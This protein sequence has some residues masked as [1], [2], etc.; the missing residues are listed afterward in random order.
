M[1]TS[2]STDTVRQINAD[3]I[4]GVLRG[5]APLTKAEISQQSGLSYPTCNTIVN[6]L[7]AEGELLE[8]TIPAAGSGRPASRYHYNPDWGQLLC[9]L[10]TYEGRVPRVL[11]AAHDPLGNLLWSDEQTFDDENI[12]TLLSLLQ[13]FA[14][15][16]PAPKAAAVAVPGPTPDGR[17]L[18]FCDIPALR[19]CPL[20]DMLQEKLSVPVAIENDTNLAALGLAHSGRLPQNTTAAA[21]YFSK[22]S[23]PGAGLLAEGRILRGAAGFAGEVGWLPG[24]PNF[25]ENL[26][27]AAFEEALTNI[28]QTLIATL[29]L[30]A[31]LL[32]GEQILP[33]ML[34][35][36]QSVCSNAIGAQFLPQFILEPSFEPYILRGLFSL[37]QQCLSSHQITP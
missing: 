28:V 34:P 7:L 26:S 33:S 30:Q 24:M 27:E 14:A 10:L 31:I 21:L 35:H 9:F 32:S 2:M 1:N 23:G 22:G 29:N 16:A 25:H 12:E 5:G 3:T 11:A 15:R 6:Q 19:G 8:E 36:I 4:R 13:S 17:S 37:A 20:A 18:S